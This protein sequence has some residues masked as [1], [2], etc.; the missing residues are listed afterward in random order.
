MIKGDI[1][2]IISEEVLPTE[3]SER[4]K[5]GKADL[6]KLLLYFNII[7][8]RYFWHEVRINFYQ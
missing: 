1:R 2:I 4:I 5:E 6:E 3:P 8:L 7:L